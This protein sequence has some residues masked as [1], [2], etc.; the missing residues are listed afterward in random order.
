M[1]YAQVFIAA[2]NGSKEAAQAIADAF[3]KNYLQSFEYCGKICF[4]DG[5]QLIEKQDLSQIAYESL[6]EI[7]P[8]IIPFPETEAEAAKMIPLADTLDDRI[9]TLAY[10]VAISGSPIGLLGQWL[11]GILAL[12]G[13]DISDSSPQLLH[14]SQVVITKIFSIDKGAHWL[15]N[16]CIGWYCESTGENPDEV[17]E[18]YNNMTNRER[19]T[20]VEETSETMGFK[21]KLGV[22]DD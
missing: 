1:S 17:A 5:T 21:I 13:E 16:A 4:T 14:Y 7:P 18:Q 22:A 11:R 19:A 8:L 15:A 6:E 2:G 9:D 10:S 3:P 12:H 20:F